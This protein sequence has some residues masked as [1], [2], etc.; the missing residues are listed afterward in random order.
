MSNGAIVEQA[1]VRRVEAELAK[2]KTELQQALA[3]K[4]KV[5]EKDTAALIEQC[6]EYQK[7]KAAAKK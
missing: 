6:R 2:L 3:D 1:R 7:K 5:I 4:D